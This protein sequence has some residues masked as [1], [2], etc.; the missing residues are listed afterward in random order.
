MNKVFSAKLNG[1][2]IYLGRHFSL[3]S[4]GDIQFFGGPVTGEFQVFENGV[5]RFCTLCAKVESLY[6]A[7]DFSTGTWEQ[8]TQPPALPPQLPGYAPA[9]TLVVT[10]P[11]PCPPPAPAPARVP[12]H[13]GALNLLGEVVAYLDMWHDVAPAVGLRKEVANYLHSSGIATPPPPPPLPQDSS[14][15]PAAWDK[16]TQE[17]DELRR[18]LEQETL[19][20]DVAAADANDAE[21]EAATAAQRVAEFAEVT[22]GLIATLERSGLRHDSPHLA[23]ARELLLTCKFVALPNTD[24]ALFSDRAQPQF[25]GFTPAQVDFIRETVQGMA[26][27]AVKRLLGG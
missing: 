5:S 10:P 20:A 7:L 16:L 25:G 19:R 26:V 8:P 21:N 11:P 9:A 15:G 3:G 23:R 24:A 2:P 27:D 4:F 14:R 13:N 6:P 1:E 17:R 22:T 18:Q 12:T